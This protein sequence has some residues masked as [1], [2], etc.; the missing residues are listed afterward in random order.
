MDCQFTYDVLAAPRH[1]KI[2]NPSK[3]SIKLIL[4]SRQVKPIIICYNIQKTGMSVCL[5]VRPS[6]CPCVFIELFT[7][8]DNERVVGYLCYL[9]DIDEI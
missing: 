9:T 6:V 8:K 7:S 2:D 1:Y 3:F 5:S 4:S